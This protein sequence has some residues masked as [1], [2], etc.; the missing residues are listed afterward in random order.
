M[1][2]GWCLIPT[3][4]MSL[5]SNT[6]ARRRTICPFSMHRIISTNKKSL[7]TSKLLKDSFWK[8]SFS[9]NVCLGGQNSFE[10]L[11]VYCYNTSLTTAGL[12]AISPT[13]KLTLD[14]MKYSFYF[15]KPVKSHNVFYISVVRCVVITNASLPT[16]GHGLNHPP[17]QYH[18]VLLYFHSNSVWRHLLTQSSSD[19][20]LSSQMSATS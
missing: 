3:N 14:L 8:K 20:W 19:S 7:C 1:G 6:V 5:Y 4:G 10:R 18:Q 2:N 15:R 17:E 12:W 11:C 16:A 13:R 9:I